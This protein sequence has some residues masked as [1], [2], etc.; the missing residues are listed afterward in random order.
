MT[1]I[2]CSLVALVAALSSLAHAGITITSPKAGVTIK[3]G[4]AI[5]VQWTTDSSAPAI[6][7]LTTYTLLLVAG[8][9]QDDQQVS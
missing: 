7:D 4:T 8:G 2:L 3:A 1:R 9:N 5:T 6:A